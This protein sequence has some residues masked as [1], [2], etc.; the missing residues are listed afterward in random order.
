MPELA[1][2]A[3]LLEFDRHAIVAGQCWRLWTGHLVHYSAQHALI[4]IASALVAGL[5]AA[6]SFGAR[7]LLAALALG[8]PLIAVGLLLAVPDCQHYRGASGLAVLL[9]VM[10]GAGLWRDARAGAAPIVRAALALLAV[11]LAAKIAAE[12]RGLA[13]DWSDLPQGVA[14]AWQAHLLGAVAGMVAVL[15]TRSCGRC[16]RS[17][18]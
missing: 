13:L 18:M 8:A 16:V 9:A 1:Q 6:Q 17:M 14:V 10:A 12:A 3:A 2:L 11:V 7:R 5:I 15:P 4:D